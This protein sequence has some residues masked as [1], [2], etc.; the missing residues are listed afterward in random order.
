MENKAVKVELKSRM[1]LDK[2]KDKMGL[3]IDRAKN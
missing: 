2:V 1:E 3:E